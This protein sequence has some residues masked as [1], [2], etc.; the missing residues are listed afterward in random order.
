MQLDAAVIILIISDLCLVFRGPGLD[1]HGATRRQSATQ[2]V[3]DCCDT[4][5]RL[6]QSI[7]QTILIEIAVLV[8]LS[9]SRADR[10]GQAAAAR[11][12]LC[13]KMFAKQF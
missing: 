4:V 3:S 13:D 9:V 7:N 1:D 6:R 8:T 2:I 12:F 11:T 5:F 10:Q